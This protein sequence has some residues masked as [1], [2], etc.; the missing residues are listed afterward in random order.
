M[1]TLWL[2]TFASVIGSGGAPTVVTP[3]STFQSEAECRAA[4]VQVTNILQDSYGKKNTPS[5]GC[6]A[7]RA[8]RFGQKVVGS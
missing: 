1:W 2:V 7:I 5:P 3:M 6:L 8:G 4:I